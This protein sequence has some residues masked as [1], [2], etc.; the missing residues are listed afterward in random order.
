MWKVLQTCVWLSVLYLLLL[1][2]RSAS[3]VSVLTRNMPS[4]APFQGFFV[5]SDIFLMGQNKI[6]ARKIFITAFCKS[7][8]FSSI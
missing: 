8:C 1:M 7:L 6:L 2:E 5:Q 4:F 3:Q